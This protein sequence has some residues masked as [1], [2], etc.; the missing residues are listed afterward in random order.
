MRTTSVWSGTARESRFAALSRD[1]DADVVIVGGGITGITTAALLAD[2]GRRVVVLEAFTVGSGATGN[3]TGNLYAT[4][5]SGLSEVERKWDKDVARAV[6]RSRSEA[7]DFIE[8]TADRLRIDCQYA[9]QPMHLY[10]TDDKEQA[11]LA[12]ECDA[13]IRAGLSASLVDDAPMPPVKPS[14]PVLRI[15][16]QAQFH[17]LRYVQGL[18]NAIASPSCSIF[19]NSA[20]TEI[21]VGKHEVRTAHGRVTAAEVVLATHTPKGIFAVQA[22]MTNHREYG[23]AFDA[24]PGAVPPGIY[25]GSGDPDHSIRMLDV[26]G[27]SYAI[28]VGPEYAVGAHDATGAL[29]QLEQFTARTFNGANVVYRWSAQN[30]RGSDLLPYIGRTRGSD[31]FVATGFG[32][33]GLTFGS[34]AAHIIADEILRRANAWARVYDAKRFHPAKEAS[35]FLRANV[36]VAKGLL[37]R[38]KSAKTVTLDAIAVGSGRIIE[39]DGEKVAVSR[40]EDGEL[41]LVSPVCTHLGCEVAWNAVE[42]TWDCPCHASRFA[43]DGT[44]LEGPAL[45]P[46]ARVNED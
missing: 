10:A 38:L 35:G 31:A 17:P 33:D 7:V 13:A 41:A 44:P 11:P 27:R 3:S 40:G 9:R 43:P 23:V 8:R 5:S 26:E 32:T 34:L 19:E 28:V 2:A 12:D 20:V 15:E 37:V 16:A 39:Y 18:A 22:E 4:V 46:L 6:A 29:R 45:A 21:D 14:G 30:H 25:W 1:T 36:Q 42:R 24:A